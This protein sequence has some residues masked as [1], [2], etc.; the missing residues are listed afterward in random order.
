[1]P[2]FSVLCLVLDSGERLPCFADNKTRFLVRIAQGKGAHERTATKL[3][4][5]SVTT[6]VARFCGVLATWN[7]CSQK[8]IASGS[9][10]LSPCYL[11]SRQMARGFSTQLF[12]PWFLEW[13]SQVAR[14]GIVI[15][16][17]HMRA[18]TPSLISHTKTTS[19][20][21]GEAIDH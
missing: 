7:I 8:G 10:I 18:W 4:N 12:I 20:P 6:P 13:I 2:Q 17:P 9:I 1:M 15:T 11:Y 21:R 5:N 3:A 19:F 16:I 14:T